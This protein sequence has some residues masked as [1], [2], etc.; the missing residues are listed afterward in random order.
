VEHVKKRSIFQIVISITAIALIVL[1]GQCPKVLPSDTI[2]IGLVG[3][4]ILP[5]LFDVLEEAELSGWGK[6]KFRKL[7]ARTEE[8]LQITAETQRRLDQLIVSPRQQNL[9][10]N[11]GSGSDPRL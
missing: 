4:A 1:H 10:V 6:I 8:L 5:W 3:V 11:F 2:T 7:E 9:W